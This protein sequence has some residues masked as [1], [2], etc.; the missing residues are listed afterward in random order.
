MISTLRWHKHT[1]MRHY[2]LRNEKENKKNPSS[3]QNHISNVC[4]NAV[5]VMWPGHSR[6]TGQDCWPVAGL[7][8]PWLLIGCLHIK[9][10]EAS[11]LFQKRLKRCTEAS[12]NS[13]GL[14]IR[15][16]NAHLSLRP[17]LRPHAQQGAAPAELLGVCWMW[18]RI[19][20]SSVVRLCHN[21]WWLGCAARRV[22]EELP[23]CTCACV[24]V[25][26]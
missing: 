1:R 15:K 7:C 18:C 22:R 10:D 5:V 12:Q 6:Q 19:Q 8:V 25:C 13:V 3:L 2:L 26:V 4:T 17:L 9:R 23:L 21:L 16:G 20:A 14:H 24:C 11:L